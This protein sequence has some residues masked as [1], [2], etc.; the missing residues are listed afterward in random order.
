MA[1]NIRQRKETEALTPNVICVHRST[2]WTLCNKPHTIGK[3]KIY[4]V[5]DLPSTDKH[6]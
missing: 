3:M 1:R 4:H 6:H 5:S 2:N